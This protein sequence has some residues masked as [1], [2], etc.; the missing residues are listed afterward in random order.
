M[1]QNGRKRG[2]DWLAE[3][4]RPRADVVRSELPSDHRPRAIERNVTSSRSSL[5][6]PG[7]RDRCDRRSTSCRS[8]PPVLPRQ[9][10]KAA[11]RLPAMACTARALPPRRW[12]RPSVGP[13]KP[14]DGPTEGTTSRSRPPCHRAPS[15][16]C[17]IERRV[18]ASPARSPGS[19]SN[20][21]P[22]PCVFVWAL[23]VLARAVPRL[24][25]DATSRRGP[26]GA[27]L[28]ALA[29]ISVIMITGV[30]SEEQ[31]D[32]KVGDTTRLVPFRR[33]HWLPPPACAVGTWTPYRDPSS[34]MMP[35]NGER[36]GR[37]RA[38]RAGEPCHHR[39]LSRGR[40]VG[41]YSIMN[42]MRDPSIS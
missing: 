31:L 14:S 39:T 9:S 19:V 38:P 7:R 26:E 12:S 36:E 3:L 15:S 10:D 21:R 24:V 37:S 8:C 41:P 1:K 17:C 42:R 25:A 35:G 40:E 18:A 23:V 5:C 11:C 22:A 2:T 6:R 34:N 33:K 13:M 27:L 16:T 28:F 29:A 32:R 30:Y 20:R 4:R